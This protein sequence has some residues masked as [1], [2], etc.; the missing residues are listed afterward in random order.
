MPTSMYDY[1]IQHLQQ[2]RPHLADCTVLLKTD[3]AFPL[4]APCRIAAYGNGVRHTIKGGTGSGEV[5][6]RSFVTAEEGLARAGFTVTS[7][8]WL[9]GYDAVRIKARRDFLRRMKAEAR[10]AGVNVLIYGMGRVMPEPDY[11]LPLDADGE[12]AVYVLARISGEGSDRTPAKGDI[13]LTDTE[14]RDILALNERYR[15][16]LLVLNV[17]GVVD[18]SPVQTVRNIL[19]LSQLGDATGDVLADLLLGRAV[20]SGKLTTTWAAWEEYPAFAEFGDPDDTRY[21]EGIYVGYRYFDT[22][23]KRPLF[24]FGYGLSYTSFRM[25]PGTVAAENG[26]IAVT[27]EVCNTGRYPGRETVQAYLSSPAGRLDKPFQA[28]AGFAKTRTLAPGETQTLCIRFRPE[29][30]ASFDLAAGAFVLEAGDYILRLGC[31]SADTRPVARLRLETEVPTARVEADLGQ[32]DFADWVPDPR[33]AEELPVLPVV[34]L[35]PGSLVSPGISP[36]PDPEPDEALRQLT[37]DQLILAA[38]GAFDPR[39]GLRSIIGNAA[40]QVAGAAGETTSALTGAGFAPLVMADGP[41]GLRLT[42]QFYRDQDGAHGVGQGSLPQSVLELLPAPLRWLAQR[43]S[44]TGRPPKGARVEEQYAAALP[45]GTALAQSW[46]TDFARLC[47]DLVGSEMERFGV[48]IW[49]APALNI[50]RSIRCGRN[51][52]YYSED[53]LISGRMA[54]AVTRGVQQHPGCAVTIKHFAVNNQEDNRYGN[55][56]LVSARAL[57]EIYLK[58]FGICVRE[59]AP[60]A[61][62]TSYNLLNGVHTA[63]HPGLIEGVLR[64]EWG[65]TGVVMTDWIV[66]MMIRKQDKHPRVDPGESAA[67]GGNLF[68]P[69]C[70]GDFDAMKQA[71]ADGRLTRDQLLRSAARVLALCKT[72]K[73]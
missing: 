48:Q 41:A 54:A 70:R 26:E 17:G 32:P 59:A 18:L 15:Q 35:D 3:G 5:N 13:R 11:T 61:L 25:T 37:D 28:L 24:P 14:V 6:S 68:M 67:A 46:D 16:F 44:G 72:L 2:L 66:G 63:Q 33:P 34:V 38:I 30:L 36:A 50:H 45:I 42:P 12:A 55:N 9:D 23:G 40:S 8:R 19:V 71:L 10:Q 49:L 7:G 51:F 69:G 62:M 47:G 27:A 53:P 58:G 65:Y 39:G 22:V 57:R 29:E 64:R 56:S 21:T 4:S 31:S 60:L 43:L 1:E 20:P 52:E 73:G